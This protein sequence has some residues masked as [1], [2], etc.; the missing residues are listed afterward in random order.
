MT[1]ESNHFIESWIKIGQNN[2]W[3]QEAYDPPFT[4]SSIHIC[5]TID[6]LKE[7][8][9]HG[10]WCLGQGFAYQS[11]C[12]INQIN[13]GDE[14]LTIKEDQDFES[15]TFETIIKQGQFEKYINCFLNTAGSEL[16][17]LNYD[18]SNF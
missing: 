3:I 16:K 8:F 18:I 15:L 14:W 17:Q 6:E 9:I 12:F 10:N 4:P 5:K 2:T 11:L 1:N 13:G 7:K